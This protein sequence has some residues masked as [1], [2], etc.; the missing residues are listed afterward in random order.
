[1]SFRCGNCHK[2]KQGCPTKVVTQSRQ[3]AYNNDLGEQ[4]GAGWEIV[5][6]INLCKTCLK[7]RDDK[8]AAQ[9]AQQAEQ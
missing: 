9:Q 4:V 3:K 5:K 1:M 7:E 8:E 2:A 6:E